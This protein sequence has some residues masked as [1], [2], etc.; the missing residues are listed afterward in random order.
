[1]KKLTARLVKICL[2][3]T[4]I[5]ALA[6]ALMF[7]SQLELWGNKMQAIAIPLTPEAE[8]YEIASPDGPPTTAAGKSD[9]DAANSIR[10]KLN[11]DRPAA[12]STERLIESAK[13]HPESTVTPA[14]KAVEKAADRPK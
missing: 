7:S 1:M 11:R 9:K 6:T 3:S 4:I 2:R 10:E 13:T 12:P 8:S 14:R 5:F